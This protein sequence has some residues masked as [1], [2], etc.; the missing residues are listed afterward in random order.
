M[1]CDDINH[2]VGLSEHSKNVLKLFYSEELSSLEKKIVDTLSFDNALSFVTSGIVGTAGKANLPFTRRHLRHEHLY[3][4][5]DGGKASELSSLWGK[6]KYDPSSVWQDE[7]IRNGNFKYIKPISIFIFSFP[8][9]FLIFISLYFPSFW[10]AG[11]EPFELK[12]AASLFFGL[13]ASYAIAII[14]N[15]FFLPKYTGGEILEP[16]PLLSSIFMRDAFT[17]SLVMSVYLNKTSNIQRLKEEHLLISKKKI[18]SSEYFYDRSNTEKPLTACFLVHD[19]L[20]YS[21]TRSSKSLFYAYDSHIIDHKIIA[22]NHFSSSDNGIFL[23]RCLERKK[24]LLEFSIS[25]KNKFA[26]HDAL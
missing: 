23:F 15:T 3:H 11:F 6:S 7:N 2:N 26:L 19:I 4:M 18:T 14:L 5:M 16:N 1:F 25:H 20:D 10:P 12:I 24:L 17:K 22:F 9:L 8:S 13:Y 21:G